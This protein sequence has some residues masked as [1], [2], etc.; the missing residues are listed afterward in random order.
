VP[1]YVDSKPG[2]LWAVVH[3]DGSVEAVSSDVTPKH[4]KWPGKVK[5]WPVPSVEHRRKLWQFDMDEALLGL[6]DAEHLLKILPTRSV[7]SLQKGWDSDLQYD[8]K[9]VIQLKGPEDPAYREYLKKRYERVI[10]ATK[11]QIKQLERIKP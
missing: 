1:P 5:A 9:N 7:E 10:E 8:R 3:A 2:Q 11:E 4:E 6:R